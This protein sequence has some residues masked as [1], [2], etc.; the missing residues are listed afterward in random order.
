M[1]KFYFIFLLITVSFSLNAQ[2]NE[3]EN[4][5]SSYQNEFNE[6]YR[7]GEIKKI[8]KFIEDLIDNKEGDSLKTA[9][10][11]KFKGNLYS[12]QYRTD[13]TIYIYKK[14]LSFLKGKRNKTKADLLLNI[15]KKLSDYKINDS[16]PY[17]FKK[18]ENIYL[19]IKNYRGLT[20]LNYSYA[21][22]YLN[23][24]SGN[25]TFDKANLLRAEKAILNLF[26]YNKEFKN[27]R[28]NAMGY[29]L[30]TDLNMLIGNYEQVEESSKKAIK[31][32]HKG[33]YIWESLTVSLSLLGAYIS[34]DE[35]KKA[36]K[37]IDNILNIIDNNK[38]NKALIYFTDYTTAVYIRNAYLLIQE[39]NYLE[40]KKMLDLAEKRDTKNK[41]ILELFKLTKLRLLVMS[42]SLKEARSFL[43]EI[44][45]NENTIRSLSI[46]YDTL[47]KFYA[48][49]GNHI[50]AN[51]YLKK[52]WRNYDLK[53]KND[54]QNRIIYFQ[55]KFGA[56][57]KEKENLQLKAD[58][59]EQELLTQ[60]AER[61]NLLLIIGLIALLLTLGV[62]SFFYNRN[63]KQKN[64]IE[65][66]QKELHHRV[67]NNLAI[68]DTF[69]EVAK[70]EFNDKKF[71]TK[72]TEIQN[73]ILSINEI[74]KQLYKNTDVTNLNIKNYIGILSENVA[75]SFTDKDISIQKNVEDISLNANTSFPVG[76]IINEFLTNSYKYAFD[77][78][79]TIN[80]QMKDQGKNYLLTLSDNG[81]GLPSDFDIEQIETFGLRFVKLLAKQLDG[82]FKLESKNGVQL[83]IHIPKV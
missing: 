2:K 48:K 35:F 69:I 73:R 77:N 1:K 7:E 60:K 52:Y 51:I 18:A 61:N 27:E 65:N 72:L 43:S 41:Q 58:K 9:L 68:I 10:G 45:L 19:E 63:K 13:S 29:S 70:E 49:R 50:K 39:G 14:G 24:C 57:K 62:F 53:R 46:Y 42:D 44:N 78:K 71:D 81:I 55:E 31:I 11:Y 23:L 56:E 33:N 47:E 16:L 17:Y 26:K 38:D 34:E 36:R 37:L 79:G 22:Y 66:L 82:V 59:A 83:T 32:F 21:E 76:L 80:I 40:A 8:N 30:L 12:A 5:I 64:L 75:Q 67:K 3:T 28:Y 25:I 4:L 15:G 20:I 6:L 74:H 54:M